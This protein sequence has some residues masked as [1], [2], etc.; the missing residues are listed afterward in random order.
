[1]YFPQKIGYC[2]SFLTEGEAAYN[3]LLDSFLINEKI[4]KEGID[5]L[6]GF[7]DHFPYE[8]FTEEN[9]GKGYEDFCEKLAIAYE[10]IESLSA[11]EK[12][13]L[14]NSICNVIEMRSGYP[15]EPIEDDDKNYVMKMNLVPYTMK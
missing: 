3:P 1:M 15:N 10:D 12:F 14:H 7:I 8:E 4:I 6:N 9:L 13:A 5:G 2:P 11:F